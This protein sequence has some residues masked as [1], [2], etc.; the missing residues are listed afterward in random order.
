[1]EKDIRKWELVSDYLGNDPD[2][3]TTKE[4]FDY[5]EECNREHEDDDEW[6]NFELVDM[7]DQICDLSHQQGNEGYVA[8]IPYT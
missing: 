8:A 4:L 3:Y 5:A 6:I 7:G 2:P 1:M